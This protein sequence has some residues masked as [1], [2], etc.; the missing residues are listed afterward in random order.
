MEQSAEAG[1]SNGAEPRVGRSVLIDQACQ[2]LGKSRSAPSTTGFATG[3]FGRSA[4]PAG[5]SAF[6]W[7]RFASWPTGAPPGD[8][9]RAV[10]LHSVQ[11]QV[12]MSPLEASCPVVFRSSSRSLLVACAVALAAG[13]VFAQAPEHRARLSRDLQEH[14]AVGSTSVDVIVRGDRGDA[15]GAGGAPRR[16]GAAMAGDRR[17]VPRERRAAEG[18]QRGS[19]GR[20]AVGRRRGALEHGGDQ[21]GDRRR[22]A[23]A[24]HRRAAGR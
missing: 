9:R 3:A 19:G 18:A 20:E 13:S 4:R 17:R 6:S 14:L 12:R 10:R 23:A 16:R 24:G 21:R 2:L 7:H 8:R 15:R 5:R 1:S 22:P 11:F